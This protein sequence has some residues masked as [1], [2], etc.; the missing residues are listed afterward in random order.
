MSFRGVIGLLE[1]G[2][3]DLLPSITHR[4]ESA[5]AAE[6]FPDLHR[7]SRLARTM[8]VFD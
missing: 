6:Q 1:A 5:E 2:R 3:L 8:V 4:F 7:E